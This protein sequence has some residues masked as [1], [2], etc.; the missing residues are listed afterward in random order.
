MPCTPFVE[1]ELS[2]HE[3]EEDASPRGVGFG[4]VLLTFSLLWA[5][6][7]FRS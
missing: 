6:D 4:I 1:Y 3:V 7:L 5:K 2:L